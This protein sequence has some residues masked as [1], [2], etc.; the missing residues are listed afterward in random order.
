M[1]EKLKRVAKYFSTIKY[2]VLFG[3]LI[4][5]KVV[6]DLVFCIIV[7]LVYALCNDRESAENAIKGAL[8]KLINP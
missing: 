3:P 6:T 8:E 4:L 7:G 5:A 1:K 2:V